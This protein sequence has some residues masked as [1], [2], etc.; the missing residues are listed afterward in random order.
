MLIININVCIQNNKF[1]KVVL[2]RSYDFCLLLQTYM[3]DIMNR[4]KKKREYL[5]LCFPS[6]RN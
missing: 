1:A 6:P 3:L 4:M 5:I 2:K